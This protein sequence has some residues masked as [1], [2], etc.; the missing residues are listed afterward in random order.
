MKIIPYLRFAWAI[1]IVWKF[2]VGGKFQ[3]G[4][5]FDIFIQAIKITIVVTFLAYLII[6]GIEELKD[7]RLTDA[8]FLEHFGLFFEVLMFI[9][10]ILTM[11]FWSDEVAPWKTALFTVAELLVFVL[12]WVDFKRI[13]LQ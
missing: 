9:G 13:W 5:G 4:L 1:W 3:L 10:L 8:R 11:S 2:F 7:K 12:I 6:I